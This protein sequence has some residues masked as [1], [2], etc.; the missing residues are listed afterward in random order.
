M[1]RIESERTPATG[2]TVAA[3]VDGIGWGL[4]FIWVGICFLAD[5]GWGWFFLGTGL[6]ML[7]GQAARRHYE[8]KVDRFALLLG[9]CFAVAAVAHLLELSWNWAA[10][11]HW[12]APALLIALGATTIVSAWRRMHRP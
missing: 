7:A 6:L 5:L 4:F 1:Q 12:L 2:G 10:V 8:L 11:P 9:S 3:A